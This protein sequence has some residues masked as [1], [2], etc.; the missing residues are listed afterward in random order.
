MLRQG[1]AAVVPAVAISW[2]AFAIFV[3]AVDA[4]AWPLVRAPVLPNAM[5]LFGVGVVAPLFAFL[6]NG[7][8]VLVSARVARGRA[9]RS[10]SPALVVL[11]LMGLVG[12][13]LAGGSGPDTGYYAV[14]GAVVLVL[15]VLPRAGQRA[16]LRSRAPG[17]PLG[18]SGPRIRSRKCPSSVPS[19][20]HAG[21]SGAIP[22]GAPA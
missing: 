17:Q 10:S 7:I 6:G 5:W 19:S 3:V 22:P 21:R 9:W 1:L 12:A 20:W 14:Q 16:P 2:L 15:D 8:A 18:V 4:V 13:Q 11:P